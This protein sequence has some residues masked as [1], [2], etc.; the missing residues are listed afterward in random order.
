MS[1][2]I[3]KKQN[4]GG[5]DDLE[6][7]IYEM[8]EKEIIPVPDRLR[9]AVREEIREL[10]EKRKGLTMKRALALAA[11][12]VMLFSITA[13]AAAGAYQQRM[14]AMNREKLEQYFVQ[15]YT[16]KAGAD[17]TN[18]PYTQK[19]RE[20]LQELTAAYVEQGLFPEKELTWLED[21]K[22]Y[23]G[24]GVGFYGATSTFFLPEEELSDEQ[25]LQIID[26]WKKRDYSLAKM[27]EMIESGE[28]QFPEAAL[29][30]EEITPTDPE[31]LESQAVWDPAQE[32]TIPYTGSLPVDI[33]GVGNNCIFLGGWNS[34]HKM[35]IGSSDSCPFFEDFSEQTRINAICQAKSGEVYAAAWEYME[36]GAREAVIFVLDQ[37]GSLIRRIDISK[38]NSEDRFS[39]ITHMVVDE[40][41]YIYLTNLGLEKHEFLL[42]LDQEGELVSRIRDERFRTHPA[43]GLCVG[44]DGRVY[45][46]IIQKD[47]WI[48]GVAAVDPE[49]GCL[50]D[51]YDSILPADTVVPD[52]IAAGADTDLVIWSYSGIF[53]YDLGDENAECILPAYEFPCE[54]EGTLSCA[55]PD[56][57]IVLSRNGKTTVDEQLSMLV[58]GGEF[59]F[60]VPVPESTCFYYLS[61]LRQR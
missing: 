24:K 51:V 34:I 6:K 49:D 39:W 45:C 41:G 10:P 47:E 59:E 54:V 4:Q 56:G 22:D 46:L 19:E 36:D 1:E 21:Y 13:T 50:S 42:V 9:I 52:V 30:K 8:A 48:M 3:N 20:R 29:V 35:E 57:R 44:K 18:R 15:L 25:L 17:N 2:K 58:S 23:K 27:N 12:L 16:S 28:T 53:T 11:V 60:H 61:G 26:F 7:K 43:G 40:Q 55:L 32:L 14:E 37:E 5:R 31:I 33:I 38:Y